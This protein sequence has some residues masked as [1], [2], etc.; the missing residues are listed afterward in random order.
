[1]NKHVIVG[2]TP[3]II[4]G[5]IPERWAPVWRGSNLVGY[6]WKDSRGGV[7][8]AFDERRALDFRT[9]EEAIGFLHES[10]RLQALASRDSILPRVGA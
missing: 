5:F 2:R 9:A 6:L 3:Y 1:M 8:L 4:R 10:F 7:S